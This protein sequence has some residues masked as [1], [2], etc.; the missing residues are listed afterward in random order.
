MTES[1][2]SSLSPGAEIAGYRIESLLGRGGMAVVFRAR[3]LR[4][5]RP[6]GL[7]VLAPE[8]SESPQFRERFLRESRLAA[9][10]DHP[11][12]IPVYEAGED[13]GLLFI[14]MRLVGGGDLAELLRQAGPAQPRAHGGDRGPGGGGARHRAR[15]RAGAP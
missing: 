10:L 11:N 7:K 14:A 15:G 5:D 8:L 2:Y 9:S 1:I 6:V 12:I 13:H 4:L 3:D